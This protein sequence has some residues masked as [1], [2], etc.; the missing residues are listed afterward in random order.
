VSMTNDSRRAA[1]PHLFRAGVAAVLALIGLVAT[2]GWKDEGPLFAGFAGRVDLH[3]LG[4]VAG[5]LL[6]VVA[7]IVAVRAL[8]RGAARAVEVRLGDARGAPL[9]AVI[10]VIGYLVV[11]LPTLQLLGVPLDGLLLGGAVTGVAVGIAAQ[12]TLGNFFAGVVLM[13]VRPFSV[14]DYVVL[15]SGPLAGEYEGT[16]TEIGFFYVDLVTARGPVSLPNAGVLSAAVGPGA[17]AAD[18]VADEDEAGH[19]EAAPENGGRR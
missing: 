19:K 14:G 2:S 18:P 17:R 12:Q 6:F 3:D 1:R 7:G 13:L 9:G 15:R 10:Q 16:V 11:L 8:T 5:L 4:A